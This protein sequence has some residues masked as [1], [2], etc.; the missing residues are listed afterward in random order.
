[1]GI[2]REDIRFVIHYQVPGSLD[3]YY[4]ET[5]R[6]GRDGELADCILL[7][8]LNDRRIHQFFMAGRYPDAELT[9]RICNTLAER[10]PESPR[11]LTLAALRE[12]LP[13]V[14]AN[15]LDVCLKM[16]V[17]EQLVARDRHRRMRLAD[18]A[19]E[20]A[21]IAAAVERFEQMRRHDKQVLERMIEYAQS[22][23][24]RWRLLLEHFGDMHEIERC[25]ECDNCRHPPSAGSLAPADEASL[26][27]ATHR[28]RDAR[29][30]GWQVGERVRVPRYGGGE[31]VLATTEQV[32]ILFPD[33]V[34]R[35]FLSGYVKRQR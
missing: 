32:V 17:D 33:G 24:C 26:P 18:A 29:Q 12:A 7:F 14:S 25:G 15:K 1:M 35:T 10:R 21:A 5:G 27:D 3:A 31:V 8:D 13:D 16:L 19:P 20:Q 11:G 2:D 4:Q 9:Q 22:G 6:A 28:K 30:R 23:R 34:T